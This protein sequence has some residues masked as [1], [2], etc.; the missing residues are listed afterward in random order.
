MS[1]IALT[2]TPVSVRLRFISTPELAI[3]ATRD[4]LGEWLR[5]I[6][7]TLRA[8]YRRNVRFLGPRAD[9]NAL[10]PPRRA[11]RQP[12]SDSRRATGADGR[13]AHHLP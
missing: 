5:T 3:S 12:D 10:L 13:P 6:G 7:A 2:V 1:A 4:P 8:D 9:V 11:Q